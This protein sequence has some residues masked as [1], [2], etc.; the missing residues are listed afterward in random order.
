MAPVQSEP[1]VQNRNQKPRR[2]SKVV[3]GVFIHG[4]ISHQLL[5]PFFS[6]LFLLS[7]AV[8]WY[9]ATSF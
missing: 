6:H 3:S 7:S 2:L 5:V 1:F 9:L 4:F 8:L